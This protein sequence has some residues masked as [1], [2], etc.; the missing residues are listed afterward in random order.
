M[1]TKT[2]CISL[3]ELLASRCGCMYLSDLHLPYNFFSIRRALSKITPSDYSLWE[4]ND[5]VH[6]ITGQALAFETQE[7][8]MRYLLNG[9]VPMREG[10]V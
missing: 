5:A 8:A 10:A 7:Q 4:W 2:C 1:E 9:F 6:Y 3:L